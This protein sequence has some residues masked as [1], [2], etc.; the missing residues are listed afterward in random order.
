MEWDKA[1]A[2]QARNAE[3]F[4]RMAERYMSFYQENSAV[5]MAFRLR[6]QRVLELFD[7]PG[8]TVLDVGCGPGVFAEDLLMEECRRRFGE[9]PHA[10][11][12]AA[13][14]E[15]LTFS[16]ES[17]DAV[18]CVGVLDR[19]PAFDPLLAELVRVLKGGGTLLLT[20]SNASSPYFLW[21]D[22]VVEPFVSLLRRVYDLVSGQ[23]RS[24]TSP[25]HRLYF[26]RTLVRA[27]VNHQ[28][29]VEQTLYTGYNLCLPPLHRMLPRLAASTMEKLETLRDTRLRRIAGMGILKGRK[30]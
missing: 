18:L 11:F 29:R 28:C 4:D 21:R 8:G 23:P 15:D 17:F 30:Y 13:S 9:R 16:D 24:P 12:L 2:E 7:Q 10:H 25:R 22:F 20:Y 1:N 5:G 3:S 19:T 26:E 27:L 14:G 6:K